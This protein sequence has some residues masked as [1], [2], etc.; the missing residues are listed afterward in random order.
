MAATHKPPGPCVRSSAPVRAGRR[1]FVL[2]GVGGKGVV[3][4]YAAFLIITG[5][6]RPLKSQAGGVA[7]AETSLVYF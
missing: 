7:V 1:G 6:K 3:G 2:M 4:L 5:C